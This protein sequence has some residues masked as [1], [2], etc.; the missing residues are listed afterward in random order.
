M[1]KGWFS[2][3]EGSDVAQFITRNM[4]IQYGCVLSGMK[5]IVPK[6]QTKQH[7]EKGTSTSPWNLENESTGQTLCVMAK[8][9]QLYQRL[10]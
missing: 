2:A 4:N 1:Q 9:G 3:L 8:D 7:F 10:C 5:V 6:R